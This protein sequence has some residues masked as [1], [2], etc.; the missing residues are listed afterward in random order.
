[1]TP[2]CIARDARPTRATHPHDSCVTI[3]PVRSLAVVIPA[4]NEERRIGAAI[5]SARRAG[6]CEIVVSD[7]GSTDETV[8]VARDHGAVVVATESIRGRQLNA[9]AAATTSDIVLFLHADTELPDD[10]AV[11]IESAVDEGSIFGGFRLRFAEHSWRL[12]LAELL[13]NTRCAISRCPWGD[14]AQ[15]IVRRELELNGGFREQPIMEDYEMALR[16]KKRG[17]VAILSSPVMTSGRRFLQKGLLRTTILN[18]RIVIAWRRGTPAET[19]AKLY[20][21]EGEAER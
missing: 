11:L 14:Q 1:M 10:A 12:R 4:L 3:A 17:R 7:G 15:W 5:E 8:A 2:A 18:W 16:M 9:G 20:R 21:G 19:L 6:A 13:I